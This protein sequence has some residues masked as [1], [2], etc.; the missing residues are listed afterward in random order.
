MATRKSPRR[1]TQ[2]DA[3]IRTWR[4]EADF[5]PE[6]QSPERL[7]LTSLSSERLDAIISAWCA[8]EDCWLVAYHDAIARAAH[9][10]SPEADDALR[11]ASEVR[12]AHMEGYALTRT[13]RYKAQARE[14]EDAAD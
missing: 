10:G 5:T 4:S 11:A 6:E 14:E 13:T 7:I 9:E 8:D 3:R 12:A 1:L 2:A